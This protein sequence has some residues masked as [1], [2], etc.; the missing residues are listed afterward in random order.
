MKLLELEKF[1]SDMKER[2]LLKNDSEILCNHELNGHLILEPVMQ[3]Q[4][5]VHENGCGYLTINA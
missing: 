3:G 2:G 4:L 5:E 1:I